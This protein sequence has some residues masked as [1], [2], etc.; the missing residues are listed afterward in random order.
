M[1]KIL[2]KN[3]SYKINGLLFKTHKVLGRFKNEKQYADYFET[4][5]RRDNLKYVREYRFEDQSF[6]QNKVRCICDFIIDD[7]IIL[8]FKAKDFIS[9]EDYHQV[10]RYLV[11]LNLEL[12]IIVNFRQIRIVPKRVLNYLEFRKFSGNSDNSNL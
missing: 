2:Y 6:G 4:L 1:E 8:E 5:L 7:K 10:K 9:K 12:A 11:T 3:E